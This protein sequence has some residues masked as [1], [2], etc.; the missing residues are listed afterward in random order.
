MSSILTGLNLVVQSVSLRGGVGSSDESLCVTVG[1]LAPLVL[2]LKKGGGAMALSTDAACRSLLTQGSTIKLPLSVMVLSSSSSR[3]LVSVGTVEEIALRL[4][5]ERENQSLYAPEPCLQLPSLLLSTAFVTVPLV[6]AIGVATHYGTVTLAISVFDMTQRGVDCLT[7]FPTGRLAL[8]LEP[9]FVAAQRAQAREL[10]KGIT[11]PTPAASRYYYDEGDDDDHDDDSEG[12]GRGEGGAPVDELLASLDG[13]L[14]RDAHNNKTSLDSLQLSAVFG[15][16]LMRQSHE[17]ESFSPDEQRDSTLSLEDIL[18]EMAAQEEMRRVK[19]RE[20]RDIDR[21][22]DRVGTKGGNSKA[23]H[24]SAVDVKTQAARRPSGSG[25]SAARRPAASSSQHLPTQSRRGGRPASASAA[26]A[27]AAG[28]GAKHKPAA[29]GSPVRILLRKSEVPPS[30]SSQPSAGSPSPAPNPAP[31]PVDLTFYDRLAEA[32]PL[33]VSM[34]DA[35]TAARVRERQLRLAAALPVHAPPAPV[36]IFRNSIVVPP[37]P[38][39]A[40]GQGK[41]GRGGVGKKTEGGKKSGAAIPSTKRPRK[42]PSAPLGRQ[43]TLLN[44]TMNG[45]S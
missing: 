43:D 39:K 14:S 38:P 33:D 41:G 24:F 30:P 17:R 40:P 31:A 21:D 16:R 45:L 9:G 19:Q 36:L 23:V 6:R 13:I 26:A 7:V 25:S 15:S 8:R 32:T 11:P 29:W 35:A 1:S 10:P 34:V 4:E 2:A 27:A 5:S 37:P 20:L 28:A 44:V 12:G 3:N 22:R 18:A 42:K